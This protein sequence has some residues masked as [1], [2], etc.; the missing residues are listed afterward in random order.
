MMPIAGST[1][2]S[3]LSRKK[4]KCASGPDCDNWATATIE[5]TSA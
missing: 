3:P 1:H 5:A 2:K 4:M